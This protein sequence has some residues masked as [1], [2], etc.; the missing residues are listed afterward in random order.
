MRVMVD[1]IVSEKPYGVI[2]AGTIT[3]EGNRRHG[4]ARAPDGR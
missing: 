2:F 1:S 4:Q 3:D